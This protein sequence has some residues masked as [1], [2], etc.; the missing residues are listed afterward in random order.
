MAYEE[1]AKKKIDIDKFRNL[2]L[3]QLNRKNNLVAAART[4]WSSTVFTE[5]ICPPHGVMQAIWA[6]LWG[7]FYIQKLPD[8]RDSEIDVKWFNAIA[9]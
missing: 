4:T 6:T 2:W 3:W 1:Y 9:E 5:R 8:R 7:D